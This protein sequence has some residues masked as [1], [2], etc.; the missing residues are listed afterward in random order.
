MFYQQLAEASDK[1]VNVYYGV[2]GHGKC[3]VDAMSSFGAKDL[4]RKEIVRNDF[5]YS[6][7]LDIYNLLVHKKSMTYFH[8]H[9]NILGEKEH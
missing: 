7:S 8:I 3:I 6:S 9:T 5:W 4:P 2:A 1:V